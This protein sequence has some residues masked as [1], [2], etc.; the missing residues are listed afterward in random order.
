MNWLI[1]LGIIAVGMLMVIKTNWIID[2]TGRIDWAEQHLGSEGGTRI[3]IK[4]L[5]VLVILGTFLGVTGILGGWVKAI[6]GGLAL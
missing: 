3:F 2:F 4:L 1:A 5:G 6:F